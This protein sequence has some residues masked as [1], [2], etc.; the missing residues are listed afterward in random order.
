MNEAEWLVCADLDRMLEFLRGG[1][2]D[3]KMRL[4]AC[5]CCRRAWDLL[6]DA[7]SRHAVETAERYA[8]GLATERERVAARGD[9]LGATARRLGSAAWAPYWATSRRA[10]ESVWNAA[11]A[12]AGGR[13]RAGGARPGRI[14]DAGVWNA[15]GAA[16]AKEQA[17]LVRDVFGNPFRPVVLDPTLVTWRDGAVR[18]MAQTIHDERRFGDLP[19]LADALEDA[20]C[21][22]IDVL[23]HCRAGG[24]HVRGCWVIDLLLGKE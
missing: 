9:A 11:A 5:A 23:A 15:L 21:V 3:R 13:V 2:S 19:I 16:E 4:F 6:T 18:K 8:E 22:N 20:G 14:N 12:A 10:A 7:R 24:E 1:V 17:R